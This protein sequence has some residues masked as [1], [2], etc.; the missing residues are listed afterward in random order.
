MVGLVGTGSGET[1]VVGLLSGE[2]GEL[3][4][5]LAQVSSGDLLVK[6]LG[7]HAAMYQLGA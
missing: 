6:G 4:V 2:G 3:D 5:E 1:K 7:E